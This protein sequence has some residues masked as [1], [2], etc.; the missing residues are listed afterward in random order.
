MPDYENLFDPSM[1]SGRVRNFS[2]LN[3]SFSEFVNILDL[4]GVEYEWSKV[5]VEGEEPQ[6]AVYIPSEL[7]KRVEIVYGEKHGFLRY[8][9]IKHIPSEPYANH[10]Y[11]VDI[12]VRKANI[13]ENRKDKDPDP[14]EKEKTQRRRSKTSK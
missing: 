14:E 3:L 6:M 11:D 8:T 13:V 10:G 4:C 5:Y 9:M 7:N 2:H 1:L 12:T